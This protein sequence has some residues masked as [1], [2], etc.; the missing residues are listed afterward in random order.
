MRWDLLEPIRTR[1]GVEEGTLRKQA[2]TRIALCYPEPA[3][4]WG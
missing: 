1:L 3:T 2:A 4:T